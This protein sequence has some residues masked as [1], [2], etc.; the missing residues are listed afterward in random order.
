MSFKVGDWIHH[1]K[2]G[3]GRIVDEW[4]EKFLIAFD[5]REE[6]QIIKSAITL[7]GIAHT[8]QAVRRASGS[9]RFVT[10]RTARKA[11]P[12]F[13]HLVKRFLD[14]F[15]DGFDGEDFHYTEREYKLKA[16]TKLKEELGKREMTR[17]LRKEDH[18]EIWHRAKHVMQATN[19]VYPQ[20]KIQLTDAVKGTDKVRQFAEGLD[21]LLHARK[22]LQERF[23]CWCKTLGAL[24]PCKWT[25]ASYFQFLATGGELMFMKPAVTKK[26]A[27]SLNFQLLYRPEPS[28]DAYARLQELAGIVTVQLVKRGLHARSGIDVQSFIWV[29]VNEAGE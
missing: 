17:L 27:D 5:D 15:E 23:E 28:W 8:A 24:G 7:S 11:P 13:D 9:P 4:P 26:I 1:R 22:D 3:N 10:K 18:Q 6:R 2:Y 29:A 16:A 25:V 19:L 21:F 12:E 14:R 20:E